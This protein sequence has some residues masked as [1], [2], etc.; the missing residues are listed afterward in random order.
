MFW[1]E[2]IGSRKKSNHDHRNYD[3]NMPAMKISVLSSGK[4]KKY[5]YLTR[6]DILPAQQHRIKDEG[7]RSVWFWGVKTFW[8]QK[9]TQ[10]KSVKL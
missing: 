6:K 9:F 1:E 10:E 2:P 4:I 8:A 7:I 3:I 5:E